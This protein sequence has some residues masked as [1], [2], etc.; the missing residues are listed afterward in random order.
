PSVQRTSSP[1]AGMK[2]IIH[3]TSTA[4][5]QLAS[6]GATLPPRADWGCLLSPRGPPLAVRLDP[7]IK[8]WRKHHSTLLKSIVMELMATDF[9]SKW[10]RE[11]TSVSFDDWLARDF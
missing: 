4:D 10:D 3:Q 2:P 6:A 5:L 1:T 11:Q 8:A 7:F 9:M